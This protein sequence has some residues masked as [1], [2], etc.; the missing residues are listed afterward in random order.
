ME[1]RVRPRETPAGYWPVD[2][3]QGSGMLVSRRVLVNR[4]EDLGYFFDPTLFMY[5]DELEFCIYAKKRGHG[6]LLS[7]NAVVYHGLGQSSGGGKSPLSYYYVTRNRVHLAKKFLPWWLRPLFH[8]WY[9]PSRLMRALQRNVEGKPLV[10]AAILEGLVDGY[11]GVVGKWRKH[12][13]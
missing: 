5:C 10:S 11:R 1:S 2:R 3:T 13:V 8:F 7:G 9:V 4:E 12:P 6:I